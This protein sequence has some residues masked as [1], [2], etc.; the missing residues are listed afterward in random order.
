MLILT[1]TFHDQG[2]FGFRDLKWVNA[3]NTHTFVMNG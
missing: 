3:A 2:N 1:G